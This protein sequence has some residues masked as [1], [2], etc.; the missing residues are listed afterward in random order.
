MSYNEELLKPLET[1]YLG[2]YTESSVDKIAQA[3]DEFSCTN[4]IV[5]KAGF[6]SGGYYLSCGKLNNN[7]CKKKNSGYHIHLFYDG[8]ASLKDNY[9]HIKKDILNN[10]IRD[11]GW[12]DYYQYQPNAYQV[13]SFLYLWAGY[14]DSD[15]CTK[16]NF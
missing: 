10:I 8:F 7:T 14:N 12:W 5:A 3:W 2:N 13:A 6:E 1:D 16:L 15:Y 4:I 9:E 11:K